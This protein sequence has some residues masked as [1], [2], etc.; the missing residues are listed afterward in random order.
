[1]E[2]AVEHA[3]RQVERQGD[4]NTLLAASRDP[5]VQRFLTRGEAGKEEARS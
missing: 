5:K 2:R 3:L 4:P 1:M